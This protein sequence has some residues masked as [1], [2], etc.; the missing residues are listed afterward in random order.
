MR[1]PRVIVR[2]G[3]GPAWGEGP[4]EDQLDWDAHADFVDDLIARGTFVMG[5]PFR[6]N[7]GAVVLL[8]GVDADQ[9]RRILSED[10]FV[11]NGVF[12]FDDV[13]DWTVYVDELTPRGP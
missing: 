5:G 13:R 6:D 12:V 3:A 1:H 11:K 7:S 10:P 2:Y 4:P 9:A 8:E